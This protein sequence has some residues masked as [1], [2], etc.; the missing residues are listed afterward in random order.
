MPGELRPAP[1]RKRL[2]AGPRRAPGPGLAPRQRQRLLMVRDGASSD[3]IERAMHAYLGQLDVTAW[4][5]VRAQRHR[6]HGT[7]P[8]YSPDQAEG[9]PARSC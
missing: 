6:R 3:D 4:Y 9:N 1:I 2:A 7:G 5:L 8:V